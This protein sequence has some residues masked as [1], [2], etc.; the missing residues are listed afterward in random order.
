VGAGLLGILAEHLPT[1]ASAV[2]I[3]DGGGSFFEG[4]LA[5]GDL[6]SPDPLD[7]YTAAVVDRA[8]TRGLGGPSSRAR[9]PWLPLYPFAWRR[10]FVPLAKLGMAAGLPAPGPL[11]LQVHPLFGP[12][13]AYRAVLLLS[14][15]LAGPPPPSLPSPCSGCAAP[16]VPACPGGA[17]STQGF[18][19]SACGDERLRDRGCAL[20]CEARLRCVAGPEHRQP[21]VQRRFHLA[22]SLVQLRRPSG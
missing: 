1:V 17:V 12:W 15:D 3:G 19:V 2:V 21:E 7:R 9:A 16:C 11:G 8:V 6:T 18:S 20:S 14:E 5:N 13:W 22:A 10:P 4:F